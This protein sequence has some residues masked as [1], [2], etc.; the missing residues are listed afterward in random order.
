MNAFNRSCQRC[1]TCN[2][3]FGFHGVRFSCSLFRA[4]SFSSHHFKQLNGF[5]ISILMILIAFNTICV[6]T[7]IQRQL[8]MSF[9]LSTGKPYYLSFSFTKNGVLFWVAIDTQ[10]TIFIKMVGI[11]F[12]FETF[13]QHLNAVAVNANKKLSL[14][15][16]QYKSLR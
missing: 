5:V 15:L 7:T 16:N 13:N 1:S 2:L 8:S 14:L 9:R 6:E 4:N 12:S 11:R 3:L 10:C